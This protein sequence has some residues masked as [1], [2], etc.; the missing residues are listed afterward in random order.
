MISQH[1]PIRNSI[2]NVIMAAPS[3]WDAARRFGVARVAIVL[4]AIWTARDPQQTREEI[5][6]RQAAPDANKWLLASQRQRAFLAWL[7]FTR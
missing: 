2:G 1:K 6:R 4:F 5:A 7:A 3:V